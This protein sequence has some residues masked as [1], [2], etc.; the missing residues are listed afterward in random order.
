M[1]QANRWIVLAAV[2]AASRLEGDE[3]ATLIH[4][5]SSAFTVAYEAVLQGAAIA[6]FGLAVVVFIVLRGRTG[7]AAGAWLAG[8]FSGASKQE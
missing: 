1:P 5:A 3:A 4:A 6:L 7:N 2:I 8:G